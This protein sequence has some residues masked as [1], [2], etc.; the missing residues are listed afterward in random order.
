MNKFKL[1]KLGNSD[2]E[3]S[4]TE[5][6]LSSLEEKENISILHNTQD[7]HKVELLNNQLNDYEK[8][9]LYLKDHIRSLEEE[10]HKKNDKLQ[11]EY[12]FTLLGQAP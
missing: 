12:V 4:D 10:T 11:N 8:Q 5:R 6:S 2:Y 3:I 1:L 9:I 7:K